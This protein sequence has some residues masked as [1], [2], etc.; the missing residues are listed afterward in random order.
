MQAAQASKLKTRCSEQAFIS[1]GFQNWKDTTRLFC[2][3]EKSACHSE[4][5]EKIIT[6]PRT[7]RHVGELLSIKVSEDRKRRAK[8]DKVSEFG[9][10]RSPMK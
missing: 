2:R 8:L 1:R 5:V 4:A 7:T 9:A 3:H 6:L 10:H